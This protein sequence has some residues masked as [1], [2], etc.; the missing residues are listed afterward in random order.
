[1]Y[2]LFLFGLVILRIDMPSVPTGTTRDGPRV[3]TVGSERATTRCTSSRG[4]IGV[5]EGAVVKI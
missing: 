5:L 4:V 1:M 3:R 2:S